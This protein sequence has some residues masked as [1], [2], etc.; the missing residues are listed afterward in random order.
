MTALTAA[1]HAEL[2]A[3]WATPPRP[4]SPIVAP[5]PGTPTV[6][7]TCRACGAREDHAIH[8]QGLICAACR[9]DLVGAEERVARRL[10]DLAAREA[11]LME[12][13]TAH[14][15]AQ[16]DATADRWTR[17]VQDRQRVT[18]QL[19][20]AK[21]GKYFGWDDAAIAANI[22]AKQA[23]YDKVMGAV[24]RTA[25]KGDAIAALLTAEAAHH[26]DMKKL[27]A[28]RVAC[29]LALGELAVVREGVPF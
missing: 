6:T 18:N 13:W 17:L 21:Y 3:F 8:V 20:R 16:D 27:R 10:D 2:D 4:M 23:E 9:A 7:I 11:D 28:A 19:M 14:Q 26:A 1:D 15:A 22:A 12:R 24:A 25:A 29:E 5:M